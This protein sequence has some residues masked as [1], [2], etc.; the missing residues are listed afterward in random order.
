MLRYADNNRIVAMTEDEAE[1]Q[2]DFPPKAHASTTYYKRRFF[3]E[4]MG[5]TIKNMLSIYTRI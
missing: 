4:Q 1:Y 2:P 5:I 3:T